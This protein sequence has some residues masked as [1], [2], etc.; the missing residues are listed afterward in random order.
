MVLFHY[1]ILGDFQKS[2]AQFIL[3][4]FLFFDSNSTAKYNL[5][6][7]KKILATTFERPFLYV[8]EMHAS[9]EKKST[10]KNIFC[11]YRGF[12]CTL[13]F[14]GKFVLVVIFPFFY[15]II[16]YNPYLH[17]YWDFR[18]IFLCLCKTTS[19]LY[20]Q[21]EKVCMFWSFYEH[22]NVSGACKNCLLSILI[23]VFCF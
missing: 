14:P 3:T 5:R 8:L 4:E 15:R 19:N 17:V 11:V 12:L 1:R 6:Y 9:T 7:T 23:T 22:K 2:L 18:Y 16:F 10:D 20:E 21:P 13:K